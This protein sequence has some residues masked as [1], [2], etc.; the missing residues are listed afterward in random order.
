MS[1]NSI[2]AEYSQLCA[3]LGDLVTRKD[4]IEKQIS[5]VQSQIN[6]LLS[7]EALKKQNAALKQLEDKISTVKSDSVE[8]P[9]ETRKVEP[10]NLGALLGRP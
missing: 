10:S 8:S 1:E 2:N 9:A 6:S 5:Q 3:F 4:Q 7:I